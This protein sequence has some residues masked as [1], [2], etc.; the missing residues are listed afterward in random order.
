MISFK[1]ARN[2]LFFKSIHLLI[3]VAFAGSFVVLP[4]HIQAQ[5]V[6]G[7]PQPGVMVPLSPAFQP[8][9]IKGLRVYPDDP[10]RFDFIID[11]GN[12]VLKGNPLKLESTKLIKY[13]MA[14]LTVPEENLWV[15]LSPYEKDRII[16][17]DFGQTEMGRDLLAQ[18]YL[19]KQITASLIYPED[20]LGKT[21]WDKVYKKVEALY[22]TT[23]NIPVNTFNKVWI[24]PDKATV[25]Q[26]NDSVFV[27]ES[28]LKV[29]LEEDYLTLENNALSEKFATK[30]IARTDVDKISDISS[31]IIKEVIIPALEREVN[32]GKNF[33][34]LRQIYNSM[35][36][37]TWYKKNLRDSF[38][39]KV[40]LDAK[41]TDGINVKD[42]S[43]NERIYQNYLRALEKGVYNYIK[44]DT[45]SSNIKLGPRKYF[46][47]GVILN[48][49][50]VFHKSET[51]AGFASTGKIIISA[52]LLSPLF[53]A[54]QGET[55]EAALLTAEPPEFRK[56]AK[57]T[58]D[59]KVARANDL[60]GKMMWDLFER[61]ERFNEVN[62]RFKRSS[63]APVKI[64]VL[65]GDK[66]G[67]AMTMQAVDE[68][69][70]K[71]AEEINNGSVEIEIIDNWKES[72]RKKGQL[73]RAVLRKLHNVDV[74]LKG[75]M[76][77]EGRMLTKTLNLY[78][79]VLKVTVPASG[80][81]EADWVIFRDLWDGMYATA[82]QGID[83]DENLSMDV[84][85]ATDA[86]SKRIIRMA[87]EYAQRHGIDK[88]DRVTKS[89]VVKITDN[90][91]SDAFTAM[92]QE[93]PDIETRPKGY[94]IDAMTQFLLKN[95]SRKDF[96]VMVMPNMYGD[97]LTKEAAEIAGGVW[98]VA[99]SYIGEN[100]AVFGALEGYADD[101]GIKDQYNDPRSMQ[102]AVDLII[103]YVKE[104]KD[105]IRVNEQPR[106]VDHDT[107]RKQINEAKIIFE[108]T[109]REQLDRV[110]KLKNSET[111]IDIREL[112]KIEVGVMTGDG[113]GPF[114]SKQTMRAINE[115][116]GKE[117]E[118][119]KIKFKFIEGN[120]IKQ[121]NL[122]KVPVPKAVLDQLNELLY[123]I[124]L[125]APL[126][127]AQAGEKWDRDVESGNVGLRKL[128][129]LFINVRLVV[130][131]AQGI[132]HIYVREGTEGLYALGSDG[133][134]VGDNL[135][136][137][138]RVITE[139]GS[140]RIIRK[141]FEIAK[142]EGK[143]R[144]TAVTLSKVL[145]ATGG[146]FSRVFGRIAQEYPEFRTDEVSLPIM[147]AHLV[148]KSLRS[149]F[150]VVVMP[151]LNG[152]IVTDAAAELQGGLGNSGS[153]NAGVS[154]RIM[155]EASGGDGTK[156]VDEKRTEYASPVALMR[157]AEMLLDR[158]GFEEK[159][160][161]LGKALD[162]V[163]QF[164]V[165]R[166]MIGRKERDGIKGNTGIELTDDIVAWLK[167]DDLDQVW[168]R[169]KEAAQMKDAAV[170]T[171]E[172]TVPGGIDFNPNNL[173]LIT[174]GGSINF[175]MSTDIPDLLNA[176]ITGFT[177]II[178]Q[179][180]PVSNLPLL[181]GSEGFKPENISIKPSKNKV[182]DKISFNFF[183]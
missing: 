102:A 179:M 166:N 7:L 123:A 175:K 31:S 146:R 42:P 126:H 115:L 59:Q 163:T 158:I 177:P 57:L 182:F 8:A 72:H 157:A 169:G 61:D 25:Y 14:S 129:D 132:Y 43:V 21:F 152:D 63:N 36:L 27:T 104:E 53:A 32:E 116:L 127:T 5:S 48:P 128:L 154:P 160:A 165:K 76:I 60:F 18:D 46:S 150:Q 144:V 96:K 145:K 101:E 51:A 45:S 44:E 164:E 2:S 37:A 47:G 117:M 67:Q 136:V 93:Y 137:N 92:A 94:L 168:A 162:M 134:D 84:R 155:A 1:K 88:V 147:P 35:I 131:P 173:Q 24:V 81:Q 148:N 68:L 103:E 12:L 9:L 109:L 172:E 181:L 11:T 106:I 23:E 113:I 133:F 135:S 105:V 120:T 156:M 66:A 6:M 78:A 87:F 125:K 38:L 167:R 4:A 30:R 55:Q 3:I 79:Q 142:A 22:G 10:L 39:G 107:L 85:I 19:L 112:D 86:G 52:A 159:A 121:R 170:L 124:I 34:M 151:N 174:Q 75:A 108:K 56:L 74:V 65:M 100:V 16:P 153:I 98:T 20:E 140:E 80:D 83:V 114:V 90:R 77:N 82:E 180:T 15:N 110:E 40:Y 89:N 58:T 49:K 28:R 62:A 176:P 183:H 33:A 95:S 149:R 130:V 119:G 122:E 99:S 143:N 71:L 161:K 17:S 41:K 139:Q 26:N 141:A 91:F 111:P 29:L 73:P 118:T 13:F 70:S 138:L 50:A 171:L 64:G 69:R 54:A 178:L 97:I